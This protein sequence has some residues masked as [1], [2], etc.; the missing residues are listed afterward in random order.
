MSVRSET[1]RPPYLN[2]ARLARREFVR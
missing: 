2:A 1:R